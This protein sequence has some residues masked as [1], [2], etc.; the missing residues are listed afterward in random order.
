MNKKHFY[1]TRI[2]NSE[3]KIQ[4]RKRVLKRLFPD[5]PEDLILRKGKW[6]RH[7]GYEA[8]DIYDLD[9]DLA[10]WRWEYECLYRAQRMERV[11]KNMSEKKTKF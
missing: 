10:D 5:I 9:G 2:I 4:V 7:D 8:K 6:I 1:F 3:G 11:G